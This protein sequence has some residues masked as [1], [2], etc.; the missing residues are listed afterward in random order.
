[1]IQGWFLDG[2]FGSFPERKSP[3]KWALKWEIAGN[4]EKKWWFGIVK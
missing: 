3:A 1:M 2:S 4:I